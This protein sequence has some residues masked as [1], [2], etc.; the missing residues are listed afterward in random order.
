[1]MEESNF[2]LTVIIISLVVIMMFSSQN[3]AEAKSWSVHVAE[4]PK[5]WEADY[6]NL[7]Y[8]AT[9]YWEKRIP[10]THFYQETQRE[11]ADFVVQWASEYSGDRLGYYTSNTN[12]DFG[13]PYIAITLG[14]MDGEEV[15]WQDR[16]FNRVDADYALEITKHEIG[17][18]I[19][20]DHSDDPNDIMYWAIYDY[21][22]WIVLQLMK[23][24]GRTDITC[25][26][27]LGNVVID[28]Y[29]HQAKNKQV[30]V[31]SEIE[32]LKA[33]VFN[34]Q[35]LLYSTQLE[36]PDAQK[37]LEKAWSSFGEANDY[38]SKAEWTQKE[39]EQLISSK[40]WED[41]YLKYQYSLGMAKKALPPIDEINSHLSEA[42][43]I[44]SESQKETSQ[45]EKQDSQEGKTCFLFWCW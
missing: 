40:S 27:P 13:R 43:K 15:K 12:N 23:D 9:K 44:E 4:M 37:E 39:G 20:F 32:N 36:N 38:L 19:G 8:D 21:E 11:K 28:P 2:H 16:K 14:Y 3:L 24:I 10:G 1:M 31:N 35:D 25:N 6:G 42:Q 29:T 33:S 45:E 7:M 34:A 22:C 26:N 5:H 18:A 41:A 30:E 17:H